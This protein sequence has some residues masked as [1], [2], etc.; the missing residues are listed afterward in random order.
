MKA[1]CVALIVR[2]EHENLPALCRSID[3]GG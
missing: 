2:R 3:D 1:E